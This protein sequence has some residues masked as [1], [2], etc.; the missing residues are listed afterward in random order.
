MTLVYTQIS[1]PT[2]LKD[3]KCLASR[4]VRKCPP[5]DA[6]RNELQKIQQ[7]LEING[8]PQQMVETVFHK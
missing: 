8:S 3:T 2:L 1:D 5:W 6:C 7:K 4:A